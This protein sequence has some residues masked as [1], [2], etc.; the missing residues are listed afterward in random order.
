MT[1]FELKRLIPKIGIWTQEL[2]F[3][4]AAFFYLHS[5][6]NPI[7]MLESQSPVFLKGAAFFNGSMKIPG[8]FVNWLTALFMQYW[9]SDFWASLYLAICFWLIAI[10]TRMWINTLTEKKSTHTFNIIPAAIFLLLHGNYY[11]PVNVELSLIVN[12]V[13]LFL[14]NKYSFSNQWVRLVAGILIS[15]ILFWFTGGTFLVFA[16]LTVLNEILFKKKYVNGVVLFFIAV[17]LPYAGSASIFYVPTR[18][19]YLQNLIAEENINLM[20]NQYLLYAFYFITPIVIFIFNFSSLKRFVQKVT[21]F[22]QIWKIALGTVLLLATFY[23][24]PTKPSNYLMRTVIQVNQFARNGNWNSILEAISKYTDKMNPILLYQTNF[25][26]FKK[27][28]LLDKMFFFNQSEGHKGLLMDFHWCSTFSEEA[29][30]IYWDMG[31]VS[32]S[33]HWA[34]EALEQKGYLPNIL[35]RLGMIYSLKGYNNAGNRYFNNL[36]KVPFYEETADELL[37]LNQDP[38]TLPKSSSYQR[39]ASVMPT[40]DFIS[41]GRPSPLNMETLLRRNPLNKMAFE[42]LMAYDLLIGNLKGVAKRA[43][44]FELVNYPHMPIHIQEALIFKESI[45]PD[46]GKTS[47]QRYVTPAVINRFVEYR[48]I[49]ID[50]KKDRSGTTTKLRGLFGDTYWYYYMFIKPKK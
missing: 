5:Q 39:I 32:E 44:Y 8:G 6:I 20:T 37:K 19:A 15:V 48:K 38:V 26:L 25:A 17:V 3:L 12:L 14:F 22:H 28:L 2:I 29:S 40:E 30:N 45:S 21:D 43:S 46:S 31:L 11:F 9:S 50:I 4:I 18:Q 23:I 35:K 24:T 33:Q 1:R 13:F 34:H 36:K 49:L 10:L 16:V 47:L 27:N 41:L 7:L 42:Y